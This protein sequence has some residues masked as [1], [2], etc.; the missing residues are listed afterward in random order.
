MVE[1]CFVLK[2]VNSTVADL[3]HRRSNGASG[4]AFE[5]QEHALI[6]KVYPCIVDCVT[7]ADDTVRQSVKT[8]LRSIGKLIALRY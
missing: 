7:S 2:C 1:V 6:T 8:V 3:L 5:R 4:A